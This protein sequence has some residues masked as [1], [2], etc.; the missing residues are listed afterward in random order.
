MN[1]DAYLD[2]VLMH[3]KAEHEGRVRNRFGQRQKW[4]VDAE[5]D[6]LS[7][8][9]VDLVRL[10]WTTAEADEFDRRALD[11]GLDLGTLLAQ[12]EDFFIVAC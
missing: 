12:S 1:L 7:L 5:L 10:V 8:H 2:T 11:R 9:F 6:L 3:L 4:D